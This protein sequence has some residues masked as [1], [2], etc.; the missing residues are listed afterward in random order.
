[1]SKKLDV[2]TNIIHNNNINMTNL[3]ELNKDI[4]LKKYEELINNEPNKLFKKKHNIWQE[5]INNLKKKIDRSFDDLYEDYNDIE[6][7]I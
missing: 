6:N 5:E 2:Y 7:T 4:L 1:M 3:N